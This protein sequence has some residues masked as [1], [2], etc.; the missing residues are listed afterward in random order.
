MGGLVAK[1]TDGELEN[2]SI[3]RK[4]STFFVIANFT[5]KTIS[6]PLC[7]G[8]DIQLCNALTFRITPLTVFS[9]YC[10]T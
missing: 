7:P 6:F 4:I 1:T 5:I 10:N 8:S 9:S 2:P 3:Q